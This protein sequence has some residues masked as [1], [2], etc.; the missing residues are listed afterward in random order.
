MQ[1]KVN[2]V[3]IHP[4]RLILLFNLEQI[5]FLLCCQS[6]IKLASQMDKLDRLA[7]QAMLQKANQ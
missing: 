3:A 5:I 4:F 6:L 2:P 7:S 1:K